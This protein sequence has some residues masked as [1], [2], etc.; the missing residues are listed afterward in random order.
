MPRSA[1]RAC[2]W[3]ALLL[4]GPEPKP[5]SQTNLAFVS[6]PAVIDRAPMSRL[7]QRALR[8]LACMV[9]FTGVVGC[10]DACRDLASQICVCL[11]DDGTRANCNQRAKDAE[12]FFNVRSEDAQFCQRQ[13]D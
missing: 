4:E 11:P 10:G 13:L 7:A 1:S 5:C 12:Q 3:A 9:S 2:A 8:I 6:M